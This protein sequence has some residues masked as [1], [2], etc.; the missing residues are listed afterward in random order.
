LF[1]KSVFENINYGNNIN[2]EDIYN[3]YKKYDLEKIFNNIPNG[4]DYIVG[5]NGE[6]L[7][8]GQKQIVLLLRNYFKDNKII[9]LDEPTAALDNNS[10]IVVLKI[11]KDMSIKSTLIVITHDMKN[12]E[13]I[14]REIILEGGKIKSDK[15]K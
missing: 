3:L 6:S 1:N 15:R 4:L 14:N 8:G 5:V 9:I 12:L 7:S 2:K 13:L 10:R 11:I